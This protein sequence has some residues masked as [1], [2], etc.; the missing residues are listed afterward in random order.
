[1]V[2]AGLAGLVVS[3]FHDWGLS[4]DAHWLE[5]TGW[6]VLLTGVHGVL[7]LATIVDRMRLQARSNALVLGAIPAVIGLLCGWAA[8]NGDAPVPAGTRWPIVVGSA[9]VGVIG[10][11][12]LLWSSARPA[13]RGRPALVLAPAAASA[14]AILLPAD[15]WRDA[16]NIDSVTTDVALS[17][18]HEGTWPPEVLWSGDD[19]SSAGNPAVSSDAGVFVSSAEELVA[20]DPVTG[21]RRWSYSEAPSSRTLPRIVAEPSGTK[22]YLDTDDGLLVFDALTGQ[23]EGRLNVPMPTA[24]GDG[25]L[26][27]RDPEGARIEVFD[28]AGDARWSAELPDGCE[29]DER[30]VDMKIAVDGGHVYVAAF[31]DDT[32]TVFSYRADTGGD[33]LS[34]SVSETRA[35]YCLSLSANSGV[36]AV[37]TCPDAEPD[38]R[39][40]SHQVRRL[41]PDDLSV[42][43]LTEVGVWNGFAHVALAVDTQTVYTSDHGSGLYALSAVDGAVMGDPDSGHTVRGD[44][45]VFSSERLWTNRGVV[46]SSGLGHVVALG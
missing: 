46:V 15:A 33:P 6:L 29:I 13:V 44:G 23:V 45:F 28:D 16:M 27:V 10:A 35:P 31:C 30:L 32:P 1:L 42:I 11:V 24:A 34:T 20:Y 3:W 40:L 41:D 43:W 17:A 38:A 26:V 7:V 8:L 2:V 22:V 14:A 37:R 4:S 5:G 12:L 25:I 19:Q 18:P 39:A 9:V 36:V 21:E